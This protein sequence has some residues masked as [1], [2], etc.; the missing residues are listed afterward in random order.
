MLSSLSSSSPRGMAAWTSTSDDSGLT[1]V[2]H[3]VWI[4]V[5][6]FAVLVT[7]TC[8][9]HGHPQHI[10]VFGV[11]VMHAALTA[12]FGTI[13]ASCRSRGPLGLAYGVTL[14][15]YLKAFTQL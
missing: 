15:Y 5:G 11:F 3:F 12:R 8:M 6:I 13:R 14:V 1:Y 4:I 7:T 2:A 9:L 10:P